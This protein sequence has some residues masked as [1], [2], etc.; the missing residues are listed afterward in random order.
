MK[1]GIGVTAL[2]LLIGGMGMV[3]AAEGNRTGEP[4][5]HKGQHRGEMGQIFSDGD[6]DAFLS[7]LEERGIEVNI[8]EDMFEEL[9]ELHEEAREGDKEDREEL[10]ERMKELFPNRGEHGERGERGERPERNEAAHAAVLA[11][12]YSAWLEA[13][14]DNERVQEKINESNFARLSEAANL[15]AAGDHDGAKEIMEELGLK[16][17]GHGKFQRGQQ[18]QN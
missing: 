18:P 15:R 1:L 9:A 16:R 6:F 11:G 2:A 14:A 3:S 7:K 5:E 4:C 17:P 12:D 13:T 8:D 10:R